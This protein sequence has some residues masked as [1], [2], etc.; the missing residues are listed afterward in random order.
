MLYDSSGDLT[1]FCFKTDEFK[2]MKMSCGHGIFWSS[3]PRHLTTDTLTSLDVSILGVLIK[4]Q[5]QLV[6]S[7]GRCKTVSLIDV[8]S[9]KSKIVFRCEKEPVAMC[10]GG[11]PGRLWLLL[12][13]G[14]VIELTWKEKAF[15]ETGGTFEV[16]IEQCWSM[17][18]LAAQD[19]L[20]VSTRV[21]VQ[22]YRRSGEL[23]WRMQD[24]VDAHGLTHISDGERQVL[25]VAV[26]VHR[27]L[28]GLEPADGSAQG[29]LDLTSLKPFVPLYLGWCR[30]HL[31]VLAGC[32]TRDG[33][34]M[35]GILQW[36]KVQ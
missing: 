11:E 20:V 6:V 23:L 28:V 30:G 15:T 5:E 1:R 36:W 27:Y 35:E 4:G 14:P 25:L 26:G 32:R 3:F 7:C 22:A 8:N 34:S 17:R 21:A 19:A 9:E 2:R 24:P 10:E 31:I 33:K 29:G 13:G 16:K 18:Y 12:K